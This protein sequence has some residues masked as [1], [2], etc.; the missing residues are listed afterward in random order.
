MAV[1]PFAGDSGPIGEPSDQFIVNSLGHCYDWSM[2][3]G[4]GVSPGVAIGTAYCIH[5]IFVNPD[6]RRIEKAEVLA[7]LARY[8]QARDKAAADLNAL[9][10]KV[11]T[12]VG[13]QEAAIFR[14]HEAILHDPSF[15]AKIRTWIVEECQ[16]AQVALHR[17]L[18]EYAALFEST[19]DEYIKE[20]LADVRDVVI[21][22]SGH[23]T[24]VLQPQLA[25]LTRAADPGRR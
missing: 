17:L 24:E 6:T 15:N 25:A 3:K 5:E 13:P 11:A 20:R 2:R 14:A 18:D 7:E 19:R 21:R 9:F 10:Q 22:L 12:Q 23:L 16:T 1:S 4:I 8:D